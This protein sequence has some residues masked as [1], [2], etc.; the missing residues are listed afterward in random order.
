MWICPWEGL[1]LVNSSGVSCL[2]L[3]Q[4]CR[5]AESSMGYFAGLVAQSATFTQSW[6]TGNLLAATD[7]WSHALSA[8]AGQEL[9]VAQ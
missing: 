2:A 3:R 1:H 6:Q 8:A 9:K 5:G 7:A 4:R